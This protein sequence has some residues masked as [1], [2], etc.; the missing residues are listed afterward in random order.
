MTSSLVTSEDSE[1]D[2]RVNNLPEGNTVDDYLRSYTKPKEGDVIA[3]R[4]SDGTWDGFYFLKWWK[5]SPRDKKYIISDEPEDAGKRIP[6]PAEHTAILRSH[7]D[8]KYTIRLDIRP[9]RYGRVW[10]ILRSPSAPASPNRRKT[11]AR[12]LA[13]AMMNYEVALDPGSDDRATSDC[14]PI[15]MTRQTGSALRL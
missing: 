2:S 3:V 14:F 11:R 12:T 7:D 4:M 9:Q 6:V 5:P 1:D 13:A 10:R 15:L 8:P